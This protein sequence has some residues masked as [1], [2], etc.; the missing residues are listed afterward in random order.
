VVNETAI[1][2]FKWETPE[3]AL[4]KTINKEGKNGKV[5][6]VVKDFNFASLTAP[7]S[8]LV[9]DLSPDQFNTLSIT[10]ANTEGQSIIQKLEGDWNKLFPEKAFEYS[11]LDETL[12]SQYSNYE[13]FGTIIQSFTGIA[14]LISCLGLFGLT[15]FT[16]QKKQKEIWRQIRTLPLGVQ[17]FSS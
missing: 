5:V 6:G 4:G 13:N 12:Q 2:E 14:I 10:F 15:A 17:V 11:F 1:R 8:A 9:M 16:A 3:R 7:M